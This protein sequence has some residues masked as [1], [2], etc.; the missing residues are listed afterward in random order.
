MTIVKKFEKDTALVCD[1]TVDV[2]IHIIEGLT[3][4]QFDN[5]INTYQALCSANPTL[6]PYISYAIAAGGAA[7]GTATVKVEY[8]ADFWERVPLAQS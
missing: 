6:F 7:N 8:E 3:K 2:P 5:D 1:I 4:S